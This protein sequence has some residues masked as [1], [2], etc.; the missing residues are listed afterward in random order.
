MRQSSGLLVFR[1]GSI[2]LEVFLVHP[3]G[4]FWKNKDDGAWSIPKGEYSQDEDPLLAALR[5]F[6]EETG[7]EVGGNFIELGTIR[8]KGGKQVKAW[9]VEAEVDAENIRSNRFKMEF[10]YKSG[11]WIEVPEVDKAAWFTID[12]ARQKINPAQAAFIDDL[13][14]RLG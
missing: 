4:P 8:Q 1:L 14:N 7:Q 12:V 10:P 6:S 13:V 3:G 11:T 5:E 9:A 2:S